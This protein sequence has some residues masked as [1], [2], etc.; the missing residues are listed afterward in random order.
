MREALRI[1]LLVSLAGVVYGI[2]H[3]QVTARLSL[4]YFTV[5]HPRVIASESPT[6]LA[7]V[8]GL[9]AAG[10]P[11]LALG[12]V[13]A[14][15]A[16][17]GP[18]PR[19]PARALVAPVGRLLGA[20]AAGALVAGAAGWIAGRAGW[21]AVPELLAGRIASGAQPGFLAAWGAT[22]AAYAIGLGGG[23]ALARRTWQSRRTTVSA[24]RPSR[25]PGALLQRGALAAL[26]VLFGAPLVAAWVVSTV[27][28]R[29]PWYRYPGPGQP[30]PGAALRDP[31]HDLGLAYEDVA[32]PTAG[33]AT[34]RGWLVP[35]GR[36]PGGAAVVLAGGGWT[37]RRSLLGLAP[38]LREAGFAVLAFDYREHGA[39]D[40]RGRGASLGWREH[41][42]VSA[43]V[44][45]AGAQ[46][47]D[48]IAV[49]GFSLGGAAAILAAAEDPAIDVVVAS[50]PG[51]TLRD[52]LATVP[53]TAAAPAWWR[54]LVARLVLL[55]IGLPLRDVASLEVGPLHVVERIAPRPLLIV[56]GRADPIASLE[57]ARRLVARAGRPRRL[58]IVDGAAHLDVFDA[59][60]GAVVREIVR[61]L[62][63]TLQER[64]P[65]AG[66]DA[67][68]IPE[69]DEQVDAAHEAH[70]V[71]GE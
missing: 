34:L 7:A 2:L 26:A 56:Q 57:A 32:F 22:L 47:Y 37:D 8:W 30:L 49:V 1:V 13:L 35:S 23:L 27:V 68:E 31:R 16:R 61:F 40:G 21:L 3:D 18:G 41:E 67:R 52:L 62:A 15:A 38:P 19:R 6:A 28:L 36:E 50:S 45:F 9:R 59:A 14:L 17:A 51:T 53:E 46:G 69:V 66:L 39:S 48:P 24:P 20:M 65:R 4:E 29:P 60:G 5:A 25:P 58:V 63:W 44:A 70:R 10:P 43:A 42:D 54:D 64:G 33:G 55:R 11:A 71:G 12:L